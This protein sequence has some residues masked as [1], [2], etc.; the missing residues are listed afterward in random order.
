MLAYFCKTLTQRLGVL[1][2]SAE[3]AEAPTPE[4]PVYQSGTSKPRV[5]VLGSGWGA[6]SF[7]KSLPRNVACAPACLSLHL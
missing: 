1:V 5:V 6:I 3:K 4:L 2:Q 7:I